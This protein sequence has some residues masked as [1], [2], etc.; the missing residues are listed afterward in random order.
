LKT[1]SF[2]EKTHNNVLRITAMKIVGYY[3][4]YIFFNH[5]FIPDTLLN[6]PDATKTTKHH[7]YYMIDEDGF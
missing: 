3:F 1:F 2:L 4:A 5:T 6:F 7:E